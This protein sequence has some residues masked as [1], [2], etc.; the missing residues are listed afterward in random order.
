MM[1]SDR[2]CGCMEG[3]FFYH[4]NGDVLGKIPLSY[5]VVTLYSA[6]V[7]NSTVRCYVALLSQIFHHSTPRLISSAPAAGLGAF[8]LLCCV[9]VRCRGLSF[10]EGPDVMTLLGF[11]AL[12]ST[13]G[14][15]VAYPLQLVRTKL[16]AQVRN[17]P[18]CVALHTKLSNCDAYQASVWYLAV[19][20]WAVRTYKVRVVL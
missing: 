14:Q 12:S 18:P 10:Q 15:L 3:R 5:M 13:C 1:A 9:C 20:T 2:R 17:A 7:R 4:T 16:Q 19:Y 6:A 11:G 8:L